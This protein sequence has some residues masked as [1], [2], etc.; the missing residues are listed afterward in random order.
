MSDHQIEFGRL[1]SLL[2]CY[3]TRPEHGHR[4]LGNAV[5][6]F[7]IN[8]LAEIRADVGRVANMNRGSMIGRKRMGSSKVYCWHLLSYWH[9]WNYA[10]ARY[11]MARPYG[12][13]CCMKRNFSC[14]MGVS[15]VAAS[16]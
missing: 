9:I 11:R 4:S 10:P 7:A 2:R 16:P 1:G 6:R 12:V 15:C 14:D 13:S 5:Y 8:R 3:S